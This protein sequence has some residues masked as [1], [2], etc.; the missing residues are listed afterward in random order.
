MINTSQLSNAMI[1]AQTLNNLILVW[2]QQKTG[3]QPQEKLFGGNTAAEERFL[4]DYEGQQQIVLR[5]QITSNWVEENYSANDHIALEPDVIRTTGYIGEVNNVTPEELQILETAAS[6]L[7]TISAFEPQLSISAIKA[8]DKAMQA[9]QALEI[10]KRASVPA[11]NGIGGPQSDGPLQIEQGQSVDS[12]VESIAEGRAQ[13]K[14]QLAFQKFYA[15]RKSRTL[16]TVQTPWAIFKDCAIEELIATQDED[17]MYVTSFELTFK[18]IMVAYTSVVPNIEGYQGR[19]YFQAAPE[20][21]SGVQA[22]DY[23]EGSIDRILGRT[24]VAI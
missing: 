21:S 6:K 7:T 5:S 3:Y 10:A 24:P 18:P 19:T 12:L 20:S 13:G 11:W 2:P 16:F 17:T 9:Y 4:F 22:V 15:Y 8:Y 23:Q 1:T 14:Q